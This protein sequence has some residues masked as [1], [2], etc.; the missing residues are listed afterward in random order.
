MLHTS[1][2]VE[3]LRSQPRLTFWLAA[4]DPDRAVVGVPVAV[5]LL[6]ARRPAGRARGRPRVPA[7][8]LFRPAARVLARRHRLSSS[9]APPA[10]YL[11]AQA[12]VLVTY[13]A[14]FTLGRAI[15]G[16]HHAAFAVLLMVGIS[17]FTAPT[18]NFGPRS[19]RCRWS[20]CRC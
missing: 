19:W 10:V 12:C 4:L 17:A 13:W 3:L 2:I 7:R 8:Q 18:P 1:I 9:A 15:V 11:L 14:V 20:R 6:A 5:L 16:I